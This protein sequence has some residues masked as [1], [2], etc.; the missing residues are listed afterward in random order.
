MIWINT[1]ITLIRLVKIFKN[2]NSHL[3]M[4]NRI[5]PVTKN[6]TFK[7]DGPKSYG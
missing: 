3:N 4:D 7:I 5:T 1:N 2:T 6:R